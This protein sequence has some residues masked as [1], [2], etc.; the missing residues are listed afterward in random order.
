MADNYCVYMHYNLM[1]G[2]MYIGQTKDTETRWKYNGYYYSGKFKEAIEEYGWDAFEHIIIEDGLTR[3]EA[4]G[5]EAHMIDKLKTVKYGYNTADAAEKPLTLYNPDTGELKRFR[6]QRS[7]IRAFGN[8]KNIYTC[9]N[10]N[11]TSARIK[12]FYVFRGKVS[13]S[14]ARKKIAEIEKARSEKV[15]GNAKTV[16]AIYPDGH[17]ESFK[18]IS[19]AAKKTGLNRRTVRAHIQSGRPTSGGYLFEV[20]D[21]PKIKAV[22]DETV[23]WFET[24]ND[25]ARYLD[26]SNSQVGKALRMPTRTVHGWKVSYEN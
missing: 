2:K 22:K 5:L 3:H 14:D 15:N 10:E 4:Y 19:E 1:N 8:N 13:I 18:S 24:I 20:M 23:E 9:L 21:K 17:T 11:E 12:G 7:A 6:S 16:T 25:V 26:C